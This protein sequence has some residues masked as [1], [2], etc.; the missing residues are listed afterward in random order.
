MT[1]MLA[2]DAKNVPELKI[3]TDDETKY[4]E[5]NDKL[6]KISSENYKEISEGMRLT[7]TAGTAQALNFE[8]LKLA[9]K[10]GTAQTGSRNQFINSWF[11]GFW[12]YTDP[13]Y[14]IVYMLEKGPS[15]T[16]RGAASYLRE[17][18]QQ[19]A[20]YQC[21][22]ENKENVDNMIPAT[23]PD[24]NLNEIEIEA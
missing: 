15:T 24:S 2:K 1:M 23:V 13:K 20:S 12:P 7:V 19:C 8:G 6:K 11:I 4:I 9:G 17:F 16:K 10:T 21:D 18:L 3:R 5:I 22:F 14:A